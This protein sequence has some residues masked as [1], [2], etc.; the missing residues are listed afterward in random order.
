MLYYMLR[1]YDSVMNWW[2][3]VPPVIQYM[4]DDS[5]SEEDKASTVIEY[6]D[7]EEE[8]EESEPSA[9]SDTRSL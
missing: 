2:Y 5:V 3:N 8:L 6:D 9:R 4:S 1:L 7:S